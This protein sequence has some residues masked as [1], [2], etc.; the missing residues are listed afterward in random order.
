MLLLAVFSYFIPGLRGNIGGKKA[1]NK[2]PP[3]WWFD[4]LK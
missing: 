1:L 3:K 2:K 4:F